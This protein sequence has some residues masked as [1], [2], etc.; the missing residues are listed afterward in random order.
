MKKLTKTAVLLG[1]L[2][3]MMGAV[4][5]SSK[6]VYAQSD[7]DCTAGLHEYE[8]VITKAA[9]ESEDG[10]RTYTCI[11]CGATYEEAIPA[12]G[13]H[14]GDWTITKAATTDQQG[15]EVRTCTR[16]GEKEMQVIPV[17]SISVDPITTPLKERVSVVP[18]PEMEPPF[19]I[20]VMDGVIAVTDLLILIIFLLMIL[21]DLS[22]LRWYK[23]EGSVST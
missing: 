20:T 12:Y 3:V 5:L 22:V 18:K 4:I 1:L 23:R 19:Q 13:H 7:Y 2:I 6:S 15:E 14:Y 21:S 10:I 9:G 17:L 8:V 16:C 11:L